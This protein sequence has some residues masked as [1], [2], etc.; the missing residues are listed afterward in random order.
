M[1]SETTF[2]QT[3][4][5]T[6]TIAFFLGALLVAFSLPLW[7]LGMSLGQFIMAGAWLIA[8]DLNGRIKAA[9]KNPAFWLLISLFVL[10]IAG[11]WNTDDFSYAAKDI[12]VKL[13][14]LIMPV[15]F[16]AGPALTGRQ[17][18]VLFL[19]LISG[20]LI[21][22]GCGFA[23][24]A[25]LLDLK[26]TN[27][28]DLSIFISHIRLGLLID[29]SI[30]IAFYF[31]RRPAG[32]LQKMLLLLYVAWCIV[33]LILLQSITA[34]LL[35][36][37]A[38]VCAA[39]YLSFK[40]AKTGIRVLSALLVCAVLAAGFMVYEYIFIA[41]LKEI[42][43][44]TR[45]L[46]THTARG[47]P[48]INQ[49]EKKEVENG[50]LVWMQYND[51]EMDT[52]WMKRS[53]QRLWDT[54]AK[55]HMQLA[56]LMRYLTYVGYS[57]DAEGIAK[58]SEEDVKNIE[59]G[60]PTPEH[61][62]GEKR[63]AFRLRELSAEYRNYYFNRYSSGHTLAQRLEY[64]KTALMI[65]S[66]HP[67][68]GVGTG[69]VPA[70]FQT[71][72]EVR[73]TQLGKEWRLRAHNQFLSMGVAFGWPGMLL[74]VFVLLYCF[75][76]GIIHENYLYVFFLIIATGSFFTEDTLETQAGVTFYTYLNALLLFR[77]EQQL[78]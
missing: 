31:A 6:G 34:L 21:S 49:P 60:Y 27:Y 37:V 48:Y 13:P 64:W 56:T 77:K 28:R 8:G 66:R 68:T 18:R 78:S 2:T 75:R 51:L 11:L 12:R 52:A 33:F 46:K 58:L 40:A 5:R 38:A 61:V 4:Q 41:S 57:K 69:D 32:I 19:F 17:M 20:I 74:F 26:I 35:L 15:L 39:L 47:N 55:G 44:D 7:N 14:L 72:Y 50:R 36:A 16:A 24:Y 1:T 67:V 3:L 30:F 42:T 29:V 59:L 71:A 73:K 9:M 62:K 10:H 65:L 54:D 25:G 76:Y 70:A 43:V 22:T 45:S 63:L 53:Y 23:A